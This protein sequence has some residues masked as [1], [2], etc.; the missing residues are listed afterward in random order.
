MTKPTC[1]LSGCLKE[2]SVRRAMFG[3]V[4]AAL[5]RVGIKAKLEVAVKII[6][7]KV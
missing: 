2:E 7:N 3:V 6:K 5:R 4:F 1:L